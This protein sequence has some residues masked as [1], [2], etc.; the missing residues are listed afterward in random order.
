MIKKISI[1][2]LVVTVSCCLYSCY[3]DKADFLYNQGGNNCDTLTTISYGGIVRPLLEQQCYSCHAGAR[4]SGG[5]AMG[6]YDTDKAIAINGQL[7][8]TINHVSGYSPM[9]D[10]QPKMDDCSIA[11]IKKWVDDGSPNN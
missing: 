10:G 5:I 2:F 11:K 3:Y 7:Y 8:G 6:T 9:P 4:P 1:T